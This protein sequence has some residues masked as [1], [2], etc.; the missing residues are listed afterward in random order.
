MGQSMSTE[1]I[2]IVVDP[3]VGAVYIG[4]YRLEPGEPGGFTRTME[5]H[6]ILLH[7]NG[8]G[9]LIGIDVLATGRPIRVRK[10]NY[11]EGEIPA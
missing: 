5:K 4:L 11:I 8:H 9:K 1:P 7:W 6:G 2:D 10:T 3:G